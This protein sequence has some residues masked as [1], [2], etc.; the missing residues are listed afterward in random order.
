MRLDIDNVTW[1]VD[2]RTILDSVSLAAAPGEFVGLVG[3]N[4]A[5]KSSLLRCVYRVNRPHTGT[6]RL[7]GADVWALPARA[8]ARRIAAVLQESGVE[9]GFTVY[10][11]VA[12]GRT[13]HKG[14]FDPDTGEDRAR[15]SEALARVGLAALAERA[16]A[17]LSGGERQRAAIARAIAQAP[18]LLVLDEP[19]NHLDIRHQI[20]TLRLIQALGVTV[21]ASIHDL[22]LAAAVCDRIYVLADG[23]IVAQGAPA[24]V[25][26]AERIGTVWGV[27]ADVDRD[28]RTRR[29]RIGY[30][31]DHPDPIEAAP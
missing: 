8:A 2:G 15:V 26:T 28:P 25:L 16:L 6:I 12:L 18:E 1:G 11:A 13:P 30:A 29:P 23:R 17:T 9:S 7:D 22:N 14:L 10:D 31:Y 24:E 21:L 4:G 19:T 5:G 3:P 20:E 27:A